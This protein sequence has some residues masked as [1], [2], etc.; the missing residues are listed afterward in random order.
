[1][2]DFYPSSQNSFQKLTLQM[3]KEMHLYYGG[4]FFLV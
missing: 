2:F 3:L 1:M 4:V